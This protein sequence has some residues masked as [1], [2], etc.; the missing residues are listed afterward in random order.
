MQRSFASSVFSLKFVAATLLLTVGLR[1]TP[2]G[3]A[4]AQPQHRSAA[5]VQYDSRQALGKGVT[6]ATLSNG[7]VVLVQE[8]HAAKVATVRC[9]VKNTGSAFEGRYL[10]AGLSHMLEHLVAGG[11]NSKKPEEQIQQLLDSMGGQTNAFTSTDM[12]SFY[13]DCP[14]PQVSLAVELIA[15]FMQYA[16]I[17]ADEYVREMGV[18]QRELEMG[19]ADRG[20]KLQQAMTSLLYTEHPARHPI[21]GYLPVVQQVQREQVIGFYKDRY[22]P[23]NMVFIVA[24]DVDTQQMLDAVLAQFKGFPRTTE[25]AELLPDEPDQASPRSTHLEM[26]GPT[27]HYGVGWPTVRLQHPDMYALDVASYLLANG[28][29]SRLGFRLKIEQP[30]AIGVSSAS[31][32]PG[33]VKGWFDATIVCQPQHLDTCRKIIAEE[34]Q[35][36]Q[37]DLVAPAE[38]AK[39]K[40]QKAAEHVF[41][42]QTV[43]AQANNLGQSYLATGDPLFDDQYVDG[44]Q[45]V[46][47]EQ[48]RDVTRRYLLPARQNT[49]IIDPLGLR[50]EV[51]GAATQRSET[52]VVRTQLTNGLTVLLKRNSVTPTVSLQAFCFGGVAS[53]TPE[54]SGLAALAC[55]LMTRGTKKYNAVQ[56]AEYFDSIGGTLAVDSQRFTSF[57]QAAVLKQDFETAL[58]YAYQVLFEPTFPADEFD[59]VREQ[60]LAR[61]A[62]RQADPQSEIMDFWTLQLPRQSPYGR[63]VLGLAET[64]SKLKAD[65]CRRFH[66]RYLVPNNMVLAIYG[67][68]DPQA[69]LALLE[70]SFGKVAR[71]DKV[72]LPKYPP[73]P[74]AGKAASVHLTTRRPDTAMV[75]IS[76]PTVDVKDAKTRA[77]LDVLNSILTGGGGAGGRL[78]QELRGERLVYYVFG[79]ELTGPAPG[80]FLFLAQ[81]RPE[82]AQEVVQRIEANVKKMRDE[83]ILPHEFELAKQKLVAAH[84]MRNTTPALQGF[85][86][87]IN[88][89]YGLGYDYDASYDQRIKAVTAED[90]RQL[91]QQY[92]QN[93]LVVTS[94]PDK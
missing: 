18:V 85:Q 33:F 51:A 41:A 42:Q 47:S 46:T 37:R 36:L 90:V 69:T 59:K 8:H 50:R 38:L 60:Q 70:K 24:G 89:L 80:Y 30:L 39:V 23:Q 34:V 84:V 40:R 63:T 76:Q 15:E 26:E 67:D 2:C 21:I 86:A 22:V 78:F 71:A 79:M 5:V 1:A 7:M 35:R 49:V 54:T 11:S 14:S 16:T 13:I 6:K 83:L 53:D 29:S 48:V 52:Q 65:D 94:S 62:A 19:E 68:I 57:L 93:P 82:T 31:Y 27:T 45:R 91:V 44:I 81:T 10:G 56:I 58:D 92:F 9:F 55:E 61:L 77:A 3:A 43:Q 87:A 12:T 32:T 74:A 72:E 17:P 64:V 73:T 4:E 75:L 88:E 28:D 20:R 66:Q 25:R